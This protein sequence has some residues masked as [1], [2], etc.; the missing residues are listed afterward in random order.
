MT[1]E[2]TSDRESGG[3][4][5][6]IDS[7][8]GSGSHDRPIDDDLAERVRELETRV[9]EL[10]STA[11]SQ[12]FVIAMLTAYADLEPLD[13]ATCPDCGE[14]SLVKRSGLTWS[15]ALCTACGADWVL[16]R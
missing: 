16:D 3:E 12:R 15:K 10:E 4:R 6:A 8:R 2:E 9:D 7:D 1:D 5:D 14:A 11:E 13:P